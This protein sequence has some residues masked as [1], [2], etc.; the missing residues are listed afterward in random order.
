[1][2]N[3]DII[4]C[5]TLFYKLGALYLRSCGLC[6]KNTIIELTYRKEFATC[7]WKIGYEDNRPTCR[8]VSVFRRKR[9]R[10][11][12]SKEQNMAV[13]RMYDPL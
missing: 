1:M 12:V 6:K 13:Y 3:V 9:K 2:A 5:V 11:A 7:C 4:K 8:A 10:F